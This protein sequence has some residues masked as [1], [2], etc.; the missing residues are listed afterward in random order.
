MQEQ[1]P[2]KMPLPPALPE[3]PPIS[4]L[5]PEGIKKQEAMDG[6][7]SEVED[8]DG[9]VLLKFQCGPVAEVGKNGTTIENVIALLINRLEG[10]QRGP[11]VC[12]ENARAIIMLQEASL[13]LNIRTTK[14]QQQGVEGK[15]AAHDPAK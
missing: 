7:P 5:T 15:N 2:E 12:P 8:K 6:S 3:Q 13:W 4:P 11:F 14:R 10:F 9:Y 1:E